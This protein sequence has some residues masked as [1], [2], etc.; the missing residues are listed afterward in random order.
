MTE[1]DTEQAMLRAKETEILEQIL[2]IFLTDDSHAQHPRPNVI[3]ALLLT[4]G[5]SQEPNQSR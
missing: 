1:N 4:I 2:Q 5:H 3:G